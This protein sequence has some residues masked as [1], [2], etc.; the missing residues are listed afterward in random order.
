MPRR[1]PRRARRLRFTREGAPSL[2]GKQ[3]TWAAR[4]APVHCALK[5]AEW[6]WQTHAYVIWPA[7][8]AVLLAGLPMDAPV[9]VYLSKHFHAKR[10]CGLVCEPML[11]TQIDPYH[12]GDVVHS[13]LGDR[14][15]MGPW[16]HRRS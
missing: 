8:A 16:Q 7:A 5:E 1:A 10:L 9:D 13:S 4:A 6:A 11:V 14:P 15:S 12:G 3:A 2:R